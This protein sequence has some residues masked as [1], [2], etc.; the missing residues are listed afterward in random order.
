MRNV[1]GGSSWCGCFF[2]PVS[3]HHF[4]VT[5][6]IAPLCLPIPINRISHPRAEFSAACAAHWDMEQQPCSLQASARSPAPGNGAQL[7]SA[8]KYL[9]CKICSCHILFLM[10]G[11]IF[12]FF[13]RLQYHQ[14]YQDKQEYIQEIA[15]LL[16]L[17]FPFSLENQ[18]RF[19]YH[20]KHLV[21]TS[22]VSYY[23]WKRNGNRLFLL[24]TDVSAMFHLSAETSLLHHTRTT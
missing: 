9:C 11:W 6:I 15:L 24:Q 7:F 14:W 12:P 23:T 19:A 10:A 5:V 3:M 21:C 2:S 4:N 1:T 20:R 16:I 17:K 18:G 8:V 13:W 22:T